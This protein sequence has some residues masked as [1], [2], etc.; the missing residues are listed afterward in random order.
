MFNMEEKYLPAMYGVA[1]ANVMEKVSGIFL[2]EL[3]CYE[4]MVETIVYKTL[5]II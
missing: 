4:I 1:L 2:K 5:P 3:N